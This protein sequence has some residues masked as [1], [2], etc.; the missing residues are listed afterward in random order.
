MPYNFQG[1]G[2]IINT[3]PIED[4]YYLDPA[5][6][7]QSLVPDNDADAATKFYVDRHIL[8]V[9]DS[10]I[11]DPNLIESAAVHGRI[12]I[13]VIP[14]SDGSN[15]IVLTVDTESVSTAQLA[16]NAITTV[17]IQDAQVTQVKLASDVTLS[18]IGCLLYTSPSPRD[19]TRSRMP[20]SA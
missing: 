19:R 1:A 17:K 2:G 20:S 3:G 4:I 15:N 6:F 5:T 16:T 11:L 12:A 7:T 13:A 14:Q 18:S 10:E 8:G 9:M